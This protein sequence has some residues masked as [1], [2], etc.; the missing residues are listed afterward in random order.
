MSRKLIFLLASLATAGAQTVTHRW[1]FNGTGT[2]GNGTPLLDSIAS[3]SGTI[4]GSGA[5]RT[6]TALTLPGSSLGNSSASLISAYFDLPNGIISSKTDLTVEVWATVVSSK[7]WQRLFD[8]GRTN[9]SGTGEISNSAANPGAGVLSSDNL[10]F[11]VQRDLNLTQQ[12]IAAKLNGGAETGNNNSL[13]ITP[14]TPHHFVA[15]FK[16]NANPATGGR[17]TWYRDGVEI[18]FFDTTFPLSQIEDVNNWLGRSQFTD[19]SNSNISYNEFRLYSGA[20]SLTDQIASRK[21]GPDAAMVPVTVADNVTLMPGKKAGIAVLG[22]DTGHALPS[23]VEIT[24]PPVNG[25]ASVQADGRILYTHTNLAATTDSLSYRVRGGGGVSNIST[26]TITIQNALKIANGPLLDVPATPP[27]TALSLVNAFPIL[28]DETGGLDFNQPTC[29]ATPRGDTKRLFILE[30]TGIVK[31]VPDVTAAV[32][33]STTFL[34]LK[35]LIGANFANDMNSLGDERGLLG[36]AFHPNY[37]SNRQFYVF[38]SVLVGGQL[39]QRVSRFLARADNPNAA[40]TTSE[41]VL[42]QQSDDYPNHNGGELQFGPTDGFLYISVGDEGNANDDP[43]FNSQR[44][45]KDFFSGILRID[46]DRDMSKSVEPNPHALSIPT[47]SGLARFA[48]PK[49]NPFVLPAQGG[50]WSGLYNGSSVSGTVRTEFWATGLRNPWR[51]AFDP[52]TG[53]LWCGDVGQNAR[54]EINVITRGGNY[55]WV[56][57]EALEEGPRLTNPTIH[58]NFDTLY[59]EEPI[60]NYGR[61][62]GTFQGNC[63]TGGLVYRGSNIPSLT[64]KYIFGD[65]VSGNIWSMNLNGSGTA[66]IAGEGGVSAF[67]YDPSNGDILVADLNGNRVLRLTQTTAPQDYPETL[68]ATGLFADLTDLTP[69]PGVVPYSVNLP[70]WSDHA[71][72]SRWV[73]VP[74]GT[75][76]FTWSKDGLWTLP[77]GTIWVKHFDM[78]MQRGEPASKKRIETRVLV[79]N[80]TGAYGVSYRWND[81]QTEANLVED[82]GVNFTL[83]I[84]QNGNQVPQTYRIPSRAECMACHTSQAGHALS[85]NTRQ[86][87]LNSNMLGFTGSQLTTLQQQG[88]FTNNPGSPNLLP[89][90]VRPDETGVSTEAKVRSYLAVNCS[91]CHKPGGGAPGSWDG[92]PELLLAQTLLVN[93]N[94]VSNGG[95]AANKLVVPG[96]T[97]HSIVLNR[98]AV[99]NGFTRMPPIGSNVIDSANVG[100]LT[101]WINGELASRQTYD[102]WRTSNFE[103]DNAPSGEPGVDADGDG[104]SNRD[105]FLAGTNP[106]SGT[107]AFRPDISLTPPKLSFT[108]PAN[109]SFRINTSGDLSQWTPWDVPQNQGLPVAGGLVEIAFPVADP[110]RFFRVELLEN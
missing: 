89:R 94:A 40:D 35:G 26:V 56:F 82:G 48:I 23:T 2:S 88:Y 73:T 53:A 50:N 33:T 70:F 25:S 75:S 97:L 84:T 85:F 87:N 32:P 47:T 69:S 1:S 65:Y 104:I 95:N 54:E 96:D 98:V 43:T 11:A 105:E 46:V 101:N 15:T 7:K 38:Y 57:R 64:G 39:H 108:L 6:G 90:H 18:G 66:R 67:G 9:L 60:Y 22:N 79:K 24:T 100:L 28:N 68:S 71:I 41:V 59:H 55:G 19:D 14:G 107:S 99:T 45:N 4:V 58:P 93:G 29:F 106:H 16:A 12:R 31:L 103:P 51:M 10:M 42:I 17:F 62:G 83:N 34:D 36:L 86:L 80:D 37:A 27:S 61:G 44:I 20:L 77:S 5:V 63:V 76:Q 102:A 8:F 91:Y 74:N 3:A 13:L 109:R 78:E 72:K 92:R 110:L 30:K 81:A 21:A 52:V 49:T